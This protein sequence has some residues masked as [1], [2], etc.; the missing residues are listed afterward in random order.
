MNGIIRLYNRFAFGNHI[1]FKWQ[2]YY[3]LKVLFH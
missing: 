2:P 3:I 1:I